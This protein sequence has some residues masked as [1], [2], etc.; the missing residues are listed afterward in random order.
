M[1]LHGIHHITAITAEAR[2]N[3]AFY[4]GLLG[5]RFVKKTVNFDD[6]T[7]YHLY[8]GD[9]G[10]TPGSILTFFEYPGV[11]RGQAGYGMI[12]RI[13]WRVAN[14]ESL[15]FWE[16]RLRGHGVAVRRRAGSLRFA[17]PEGLDLE[18]VVNRTAEPP[19]S[20]TASGIPPIHALQG[21]DGVRAYTS[22]PDR[23]AT[24]LGDVLRFSAAA[25][26][27]PDG[28]Q[29]SAAWRLEG[30]GRSSGYVYDAAPDVRPRQGAGT[31]HHIAWATPD[32]QQ[33]SWRER[34]TRSGLHPTPII[35][36]TYFRSVYFREPS[37]VL[38]EIATLGPGFTVDEPLEHLGERL[39]L[40][41]RYEH[42]RTRFLPPHQRTQG[43]QT[44]VR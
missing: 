9:H 30:G 1:E 38:F 15:A 39:A 25:D 8:Y 22:Q 3:L 13:V 2:A 23:S 6:P 32:E 29:A 11:P 37:D 26:H 17:D 27:S 33:S 14:D 36:R 40:P 5:L 44:H 12:H 42:L 19:L 28:E 41:P 16:D 43:G 7:A 34:V 4:A 35:D 21:F 24:L 18:L 20:A 10:G 31:V